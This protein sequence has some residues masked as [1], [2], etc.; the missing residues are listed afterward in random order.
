M[1]ETVGFIGLGV[2]GSALSAHLLAAGWQVAGYDI[3]P[4]ALAAHQERGGQ[5]A[6]GPDGTAAAADVIVTSLPHAQALH[7]V[8]HQLAAPP[9]RVVIETS[10][11]PVPVKEEARDFLAERGAVLLDCPLSGTGGQARNKDVVAYLSGPDGAKARAEPVLRAMTRGI[12][13]VGAF[14]NGSAA[15]VLCTATS[16]FAMNFTADPLPNSPT[17]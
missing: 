11:L 5:V 15:A 8:T 2:M 3:D 13:D 9:G 12:H 6:A 1:T 16:R 7:D 10:T 14:G 4:A 17:S